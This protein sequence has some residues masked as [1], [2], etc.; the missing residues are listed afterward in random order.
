MD[1]LN[2]DAAQRSSLALPPELNFLAPFVVDEMIR[3]GKP[4]DGG[5][6]IPRS[7]TLEVDTLVS[8]GVSTDWSFDQHFKRLNPHIQIHAYDHTISEDL[9]RRSYQRGLVHFL[10]GTIS[11]A[12]LSERRTLLRSYRAFFSGDARHFAERIH[13]RLDTPRDITIDKV[14]ARTTSNRIFLKIDIEGSEYRIIDS[15]LGNAAR[16]VGMVIEFHDTDPLRQVF[17]RAVKRLQEAFDIVHFHANNFGA[18]AEDNLPEVVEL[19]F[20][21]AA[22][23]R[24]GRRSHLPLAGLD[25]PNNPRRPDY[26]ISFSPWPSA[27]TEAPRQRCSHS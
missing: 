10:L 9:F 3:V 12:D 22:V 19:T 11:R 20:A 4:N 18:V 25:N 14:L 15:L 24:V 23:A 17:C 13:N 7:S 1:E 6:V 16:I 21:R 5:Y 8:L 27:T 2:R 26:E